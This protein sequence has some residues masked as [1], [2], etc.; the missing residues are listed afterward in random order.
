MKAVTPDQL[1]VVRHH[2]PEGT[3]IVIVCGIFNAFV[4]SFS[5]ASKARVVNTLNPEG[6]YFSTTDF[7]VFLFLKIFFYFLTFSF[8]GGLVS[9]MTFEGW[10]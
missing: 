3:Y 2:C 5:S 1:P 9:V 10:F 7:F 4:V 8:S 6:R